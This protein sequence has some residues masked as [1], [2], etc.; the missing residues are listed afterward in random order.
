MAAS[1]LL[2]ALG[3]GKRSMFGFGTRQSGR[4]LSRASSVRSYST[5][6]RPRL[7]QS[8]RMNSSQAASVA[9]RNG[10]AASVAEMPIFTTFQKGSSIKT[11]VTEALSQAQA[12]HQAHQAAHPA[13]DA[14]AEEAKL[15]HLSDENLLQKMRNGELPDHKLEKSLLNL[16]RAVLLRRTYLLEKMGLETPVLEHLPFQHYDYNKVVGQCCEN[17]IGYIP[18][19]WQKRTNKL[20]N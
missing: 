7:G 12:T 15:D 5:V 2:T 13:A 10:S 18:V 20:K 3:R 16:E 9:A 4:F 6:F 1:L 8:V 11:S 19:R 14:K 17:V